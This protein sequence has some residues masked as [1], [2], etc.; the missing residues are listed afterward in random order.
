MA[1]H[2]KLEIERTISP[3][4]RA[5]GATVGTFRASYERRVAERVGFEPN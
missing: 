5:E 2:P 4:S 3:P 1:C